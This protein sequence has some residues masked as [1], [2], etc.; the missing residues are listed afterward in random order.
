MGKRGGGGAAPV[1]ALPAGERGSPGLEGSRMIGRATDGPSG[2][3][4]GGGR[5]EWL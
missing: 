1:A 5:Y 4:K 2:P 3:K